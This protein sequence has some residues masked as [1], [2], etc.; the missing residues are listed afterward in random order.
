MSDQFYAGYFFGNLWRK[1]IGGN[2][3]P[4]NNRVV[5]AVLVISIAFLLPSAVI[6]VAASLREPLIIN[7][8][9][10]SIVCVLYQL[11]RFRKMYKLCFLIYAVCS[12]AA[13]ATTFFY[14][15]GTKGPALFLSFL[16]FQ[17]LIAISPRQQHLLWTILHIILGFFLMY[18]EFAIPGSVQVHYPNKSSRF[19]D[20]A[21]TYGVALLF[22]YLI[23][24]HLRKSYEKE[25]RIAQKRAELM[26]LKSSM[27]SK[28]NEQLKKIAWVQS[29]EVRN[30]VATIM[31]LAETLNPEKAQDEENEKAIRGLKQASEELDKVIRKINSLTV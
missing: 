21:I 8:I 23:T 9:L 19:T 5:N 1:L 15:D 6:N 14:N 30:H 16:S 7:C 26:Q 22:V 12:Y 3:L 2:D 28:Q 11:S 25:K 10:I 27:I 24:I 20:M 31:G 17:L 4:E 29:H 13:L 18:V